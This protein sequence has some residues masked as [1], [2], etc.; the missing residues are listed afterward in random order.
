MKTKNSKV[1]QSDAKVFKIKRIEFIA[2]GESHG[3]DVEGEV[4][5]AIPFGYEDDPE[6]RPLTLSVF[7][8]K[9]KIVK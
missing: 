4:K 3:W 7:S 5:L 1:S 9:E 6:P 8:M 2:N